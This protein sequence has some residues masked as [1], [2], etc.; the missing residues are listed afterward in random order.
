M[1]AI[2]HQ[3]SWSALLLLFIGINVAVADS[4]PAWIGDNMV[5]QQNVEILLTGTAHLEKNE[6][7]ISVVCPECP[8]IKRYKPDSR[9]K[10]DGTWEIT[11]PELAPGGPYVLRFTAS[12]TDRELWRFTNVVVGKVWFVA[13]PPAPC[14]PF[15]NPKAVS[16]SL[17][18]GTFRFAKLGSDLLGR[19]SSDF[20]VRWRVA[21]TGNLQAPDREFSNQG[22]YLAQ[23]LI[24]ANPSNFVGVVE[25]GT[26]NPMPRAQSQIPPNPFLKIN[27]PAKP[28]EIR[29]AEIDLQDEWGRYKSKVADLKRAGLVTNERPPCLFRLNYFSA[30]VGT[31]I[32]FPITGMLW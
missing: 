1:K 14:V 13:C 25:L 16:A 23:A 9:V 30:D 2:C 3:R 22:T 10:K 31:L 24:N 19:S 5:L 27:H 12:N 29:N 32:P 26:N 21:Q 17:P 20:P 15:G 8:A 7:R 18:Q 11:L 6:R 28:F 4:L